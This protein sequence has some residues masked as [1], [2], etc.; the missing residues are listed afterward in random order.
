MRIDP[1]LVV[2]PTTLD[3]P[4]A[5]TPS[6]PPAAPAAATVV[7][8]SAAASAAPPPAEAAVNVRLLKIRAMLESGEYPVDLDMLASRIVD[9]EMLRSRK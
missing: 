1:N 5:Q 6:T 7:H 3:T 4:R 9:D 8:L 2:S